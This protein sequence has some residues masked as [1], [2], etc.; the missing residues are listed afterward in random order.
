ML[1]SSD[2]AVS[3]NK[4]FWGLNKNKISIEDQKT[5]KA[6]TFTLRMKMM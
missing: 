6:E 5:Q 3:Q 2:N 1:V 4:A